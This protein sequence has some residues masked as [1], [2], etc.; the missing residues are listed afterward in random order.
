MNI[1]MKN[2]SPRIVASVMLASFLAASGCGPNPN[3]QIL[4]QA[5]KE[6]NDKFLH[7]DESCYG[8]ELRF[9][10]FP[11]VL[12]EMKEPSIEVEPWPQLDEGDKANGIEWRGDIHFVCKVYR[13]V[14]VETHQETKD[15]RVQGKWSEWRDGSRKDTHLG[16]AGGVPLFAPDVTGSVHL[17]IRKGQWEWCVKDAPKPTSDIVRKANGLDAGR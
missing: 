11:M 5:Q 4:A 7:M 3:A 14:F 10:G 8:Y 16:R 13:T 17:T 1:E 9:D 6:M 12:V 15:V 2:H